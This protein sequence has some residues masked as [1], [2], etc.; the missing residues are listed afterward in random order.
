MIGDVYA[1]SPQSNYKPSKEVGDLTA[2]VKKDYGYGHE[3]LHRP[4]TELNERSVIDDMNRGQRTFNAFV[5][6]EIE[7]PA[8]AWKWRGTRSKARNKAVAMHAQLTSS[9]IYPSF[10]A[11]NESDEEDRDFSEMMNDCV[12]WLGG[13]SNYRSSF[14]AVSMGMLVNPV[15]YM[16]AQWNE[17]YQTIKERDEQGELQRTEIIDE[18]L[19]GFSAPIWSADQILISNAYEQNIQRHRFNIKRRYIEYSEAQAKHRL[20]ENWSNVQPGVKAVYNDDDGLFYDIKDEDHPHLVEETTYCSRRED[21]EIVF[22]NGIYMGEEDV[23]ANPMT[24]RDN[25][26]APKYDIVPFGYQRV[27]EHFFFYKSLMNSQ[28]WDNQLLDAQYELGMNR[29]FLESSMPTGFSGVGEEK[30]D[31]DIMYP[32]AVVAF[33]DPNAKSFPLLQ[34]GGVAPLFSAMRETERSMDEG[35]ISET[36]MGALPDA[37]QKATT[38]AIANQNAKTMLEGVGKTLAE[39][40]IQYGDLMSGIVVQQLSIAQVDEIVGDETRLHYRSLILKDKVVDGKAVDKVLR[41]DESLLGAEMTEEDKRMEGLKLLGETKYPDNPKHIYRIN[42]MRF[43]MMKYLCR[44]E[45]SVMFPKN[46]EYMQGIMSQ[47]YAQFSTN[48]FVSL[49]ELT[50]RSL[51]YYFK[52]D[53]EKLMKP[54]VGGPPTLGMAEKP[55]Q[56]T[57]GQQAQNTKTS[58]LST[59]PSIGARAP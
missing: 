54:Q 55:P 22:V 36:S 26:N 43:S 51:Y 45:P 11:Q 32:S 8:D 18:T 33:K 9:Y 4:W 21:T 12:E 23:D 2:F 13:N 34:S 15:T 27:N 5:D 39:S 38:V 59:T 52:G 48:P 50:R 14:L 42:P 20:H 56:T 17:V 49:E 28:Y 19:S 1:N 37:G 35:S 53:T 10:V 31:S 40:M 16:G 3:I 25:R 58:P 57:F 7:N 44:I 47:V 41:F 24:S 46:E 29:A 30:I 6:E